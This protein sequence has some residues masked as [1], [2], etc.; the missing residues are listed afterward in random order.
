MYLKSVVFLKGIQ[1]DKVVLVWKGTVNM[2]VEERKGFIASEI[3]WDRQ[4][5]VRYTT[6][7]WSK[8]RYNAVLTVYIYSHST[9]LKEGVGYSIKTKRRKKFKCLIVMRLT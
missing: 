5:I 4:G 2:F 9:W 1:S 7:P 6:N 3:Q 8:D